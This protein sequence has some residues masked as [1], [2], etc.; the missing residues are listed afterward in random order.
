M[1]HFLDTVAGGGKLKSMN[2]I[3]PK[4]HK[5]FTLVELL[6]VIVIIGIL[7]AISLVTY[8]GVQQRANLASVQQDMNN[9][10]KKLEIYNVENGS[11]PK[12][13]SN[14]PSLKINK[15]A[16]LTSGNNG[17]ACLSG[18]GEKYAIGLRPKGASGWSGYIIINGVISETTEVNAT[19]VC[20]AID[21]N[22]SGSWVH[23]GYV[24]S[25][26]WKTGIWE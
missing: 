9:I 26:G 17:W 6:I 11:Y 18:D 12:T 5:G 22:V 13:I 8:N 25:T 15:S 20:G 14:F 19:T 21:M 10:V 2:T 3:H 1:H 7:A 24:P 23:Y 4:Q 16:Y